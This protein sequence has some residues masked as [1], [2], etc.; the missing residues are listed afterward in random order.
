M[1]FT[2]DS[3][4]ATKA[5]SVPSRPSRGKRDSSPPMNGPRMKPSPNEMPM[6]AIPRERRSGVVTSA[7]YAW[8]TAMLAVAMPLNARAA[9]TSGSVG[10]NPSRSIPTDDAKMLQSS[11]GRRPTR[12]DSRPQI[13]MKTN[14]MMEKIAPGMV[15]TKSPAPSRRAIEGRNGI[16]SPNPSRS[17]NTVRNN[18]PS[19][20]ARGPVGAATGTVVIGDT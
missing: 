15:A 8:A 6:I 18:V 4:A 17:R 2:A 3:A 19:E 12:S 16:T 10:A 7:M 9:S 14:C 13:G 1:K 20:A 5:G 11:T